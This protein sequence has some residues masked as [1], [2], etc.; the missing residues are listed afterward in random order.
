MPLLG[1]DGISDP[2]DG[3]TVRLLLGDNT[4]QQI[5]LVTRRDS[6]QN[7]RIL[8]TRILQRTVAGAVTHHSHY[9]N[10]CGYI[11]HDICV[12]IHNRYIVAIIGKLYR[13]HAPDLSAADDDNLHNSPLS[14]KL[15]CA[16]C[17]QLHA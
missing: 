11:P 2:G 14:C 5:D 1:I 6:D 17:A 12:C 16:P 7:V 15:T 13:E 10:L 3:V 9:I 8:Q 4:G